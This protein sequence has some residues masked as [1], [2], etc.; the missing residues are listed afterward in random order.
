MKKNRVGEATLV[1]IMICH[2]ATIIEAVVLVQEQTNRDK[3]EQNLAKEP[4]TYGHLIYV[5][6]G[7]AEKGEDGL[8]MN[9]MGPSVY[10]YFFFK[11]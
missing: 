4:P 6:G 10:P 5:R 8:A 11:T 2:K 7:T 9:G 1:N 3:T